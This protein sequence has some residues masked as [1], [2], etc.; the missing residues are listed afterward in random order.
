MGVSRLLEKAKGKGVQPP[1]DA[2]PSEDVL[3]IGDMVSKAKSAES[4]SKVDSK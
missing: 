3:T 1:V 4:K 2:N